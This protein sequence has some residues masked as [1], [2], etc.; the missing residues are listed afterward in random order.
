MFFNSLFNSITEVSDHR[1]LLLLRGRNSLPTHE[2]KD[3]CPKGRK[4][5]SGLTKQ[6]PPPPSRTFTFAPK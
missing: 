1:L 3:V 6:S 2:G 4:V 5:V